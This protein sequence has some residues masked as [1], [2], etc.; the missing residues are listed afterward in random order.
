MTETTPKSSS[1]SR[2]KSKKG[3]SYYA[4]TNENEAF[5]EYGEYLLDEMEKVDPEKRAII[6]SKSSTLHFV[7][8]LG[9]AS[10]R[11]SRSIK[12]Y[13]FKDTDPNQDRYMDASKV[14]GVTLRSDE[15]LMIRQIDMSTVKKLI[16]RGDEYYFDIEN[17][18]MAEDISISAGE[19]FHLSMYEFF[20]LIIRPEYSGLFEVNGDP[21]GAE[22]RAIANKVIDVDNKDR[23]V[24]LKN[25]QGTRQFKLPT[26]TIQFYAKGNNS[27]KSTMID[28]DIK[29]SSGWETKEEYKR[30]TPLVNTTDNV[31]RNKDKLEEKEKKELAEHHAQSKSNNEVQIYNSSTIQAISLN[32][33]LKTSPISRQKFK[34]TD[35]VQNYGL[36][37]INMMEPAQK[38]L[39]GSKSSELHFINRLMYVTMTRNRFVGFRLWSEFTI[40]VPVIS[41]TKDGS[42]DIFPE[43][44]ITTRVIAAGDQFNLNFFEFMFLVCHPD[45]A[46][47][48]EAF[49]NPKGVSFSPNFKQYF[50]GHSRLPLPLFK[51]ENEKLLKELNPI[52][53]SSTSTGKVLIKHEFLN[54][55][56]E[57]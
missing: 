6:N 14:I 37:L 57:L 22:L 38:L 3:S 8:L 42:T 16:T 49:G 34:S 9:T 1:T 43:S 20:F 26:P 41:I 4:K 45:Y 53:I 13:V 25:I 50:N 31:R 23:L 18:F 19:E 5:K 27:P 15:P 52:E 35:E 54:Q 36:G 55:F 17:D 40:E 28:I 2:R 24:S 39:I 12:G 7:N 29:R 33:W 44:D 47:Y 10:R 30:F 56:G 11:K 21:L 48:I 32:R 46:G 51:F